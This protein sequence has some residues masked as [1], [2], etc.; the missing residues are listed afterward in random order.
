MPFISQE[1]SAS[2]LSWTRLQIIRENI[3]TNNH[4]HTQSTHI[5][6]VENVK[7]NENIIRIM[8]DISHR[9]ETRE[10]KKDSDK[11]IYMKT[12]PTACKGTLRDQSARCRSPPSSSSTDKIYCP[13]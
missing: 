4:K 2:L 6:Q 7:T 5:G 12:L 8:F 10:R 13:G 1:A 11:Y 9:V 3:Q